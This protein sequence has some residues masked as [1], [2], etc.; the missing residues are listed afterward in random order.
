MKSVI[1]LAL[2]AVLGGCLQYTPM[3]TC[4][5]YKPVHELT[6][7]LMETFNA[8]NAPADAGKYPAGWHHSAW[9]D[10]RVVTCGPTE[11]HMR[12]LGAHYRADGSEI[13]RID[14]RY[15][16]VR[17]ETGWRFVGRP[18]GALPLP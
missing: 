14:V 9:T 5:A 12:A 4:P 1:F 3:S 17:E 6:D 10:R 7:R 15:G 13:S 11:A 2:F 8:G 18:S 16:F